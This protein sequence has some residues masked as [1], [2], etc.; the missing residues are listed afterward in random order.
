MIEKNNKIIALTKNKTKQFSLVLNNRLVELFKKEC[1]KNNKKQTQLI[2]I[3]M[4]Y[5]IDKSGLL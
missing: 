3:W 5:Y 4:I 1:D 2:E